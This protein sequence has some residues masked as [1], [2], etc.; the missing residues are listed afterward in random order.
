MQ[1]EVVFDVTQSGYRGWLFSSFGLVVILLGAVFRHFYPII[2]SKIGYS[3]EIR[4]PRA[5]AI[6]FYLSYCFGV[7][8]TITAF[9]S[10]Y[11]EYI[12]LRD[13]L[14]NGGADLVEGQVTHFFSMPY[15]G[16]IH[17]TFVVGGKRFSYSDYEPSSGFNNTRSHGG[18]IREGLQVRIWHID[19]RIA[20]LEI[21]RDG[22]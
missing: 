1:Y 4:Y 11:S 15:E 12:N 14:Q 17:E 3:P 6:F 5:T 22:Q 9:F 7:L 20:R 10:T 13:G 18:P 21:A 16:H 19:G 2:C 8:W